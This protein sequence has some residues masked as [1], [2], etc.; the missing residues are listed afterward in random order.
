MD[1]EQNITSDIC[2]ITGNNLE[3]VLFPDYNNQENMIVTSDINA[4][5]SR[6]FKFFY[7]KKYSCIIFIVFSGSVKYNLIYFKLHFLFILCF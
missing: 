5:S 6:E 7:A 3:A 2:A 4:L 1:S